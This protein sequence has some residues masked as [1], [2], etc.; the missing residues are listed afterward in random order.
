MY[1]S[2]QV[3]TSD[4]GRFYSF[5]RVFS[6]V[7]H[8]GMKVKI[9]GANYKPGSK[10]DLYKDNISKTVLM[11]GRE[12]KNIADVPCGNLCSLVGIDKYITKTGTI[13]S[14]S[15]AHKIKSMKYSVS[16]VVRVAVKPKNP[17][18]LPKLIKGM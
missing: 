3:P 8:T 12:T 2:K 13:T 4:K 5:G 10:V 1:I 7:V 16:P 6:G 17:S 15:E 11:M 9:L 14:S 18:E